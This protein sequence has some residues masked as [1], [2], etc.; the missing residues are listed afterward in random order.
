MTI[1]P[2][3]HRLR[4]QAEYI[5]GPLWS[6]PIPMGEDEARRYVLRRY[7][8]AEKICA[9]ARGELDGV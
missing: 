3:P 7:A 8:L 4:E 6:W 9:I 5:F 2:L 1:L